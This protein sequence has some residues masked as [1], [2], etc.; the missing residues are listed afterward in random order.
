MDDPRHFFLPLFDSAS[1]LLPL[2][3]LFH[4]TT[5]ESLISLT[6]FLFSPNAVRKYAG[7]H[8]G[9]CSRTEG[10]KKAEP[11]TG[12]L[13]KSRLAQISTSIKEIKIVCLVQPTGR[14]SLF[15]PL[16]LAFVHSGHLVRVPPFLL[17]PPFH[18]LFV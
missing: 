12:K 17:D 2:L 7:K 4:S 3:L 15:I 6:L 1:S 9:I 14:R 10:E 16:S 8:K 5:P 18:N 13:E 11:A